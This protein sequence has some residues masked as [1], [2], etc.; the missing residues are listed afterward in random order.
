MSST[1]MTPG[2]VDGIHSPSSSPPSSP[3]SV[4]EADM[5]YHE[6]K[7][8]SKGEQQQNGPLIQLEHYLNV[9]Q[10]C[11]SMFNCKSKTISRRY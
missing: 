8:A 3:P 7:A 9:T 2:S 4:H 6:P 10:V 11:Y 1:P 5:E